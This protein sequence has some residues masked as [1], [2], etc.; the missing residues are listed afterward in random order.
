MHVKD[1]ASSAQKW[2]TRAANAMPDYQAGVQGAGQRWADGSTS[3]EQAYVSGVTS[4][5]NAGSY[6]KGV[7]KAGAAKYQDRATKFGP[8]RF[9]QGVQG[10]APDYQKGVQPFITALNSTQL[11]PR[12]ARSGS[13]N[14]AR[15]QA[16]IDVMR[17]TRQAQLG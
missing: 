3:S 11:P 17:A 4:A 14:I 6:G 7:R 2:S 13:Q 15:V 10:S 1:A 5:A 8:Q 12:G 9:Q 16:V